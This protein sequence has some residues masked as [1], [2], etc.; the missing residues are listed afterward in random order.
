[1]KMCGTCQPQ[2]TGHVGTKTNSWPWGAQHPTGAEGQG[3]YLAPAPSRYHWPGTPWLWSRFCPFRSGWCCTAGK[4]K[5]LGL[6]GDGNGSSGGIYGLPSSGMYVCV[7]GWRDVEEDG[8]VHT[9]CFWREKRVITQ[10]FTPFTWWEQGGSSGQPNH[11]QPPTEPSSSMA[12]ALTVSRSGAIYKALCQRGCGTACL[13]KRVKKKNKKKSRRRRGVYFCE[14][15]QQQTI[16]TGGFLEP[17]W[18]AHSQGRKFLRSVPLSAPIP[19][20]WPGG[21]DR[22][23]GWC[24]M[25]LP[26]DRRNAADAQGGDRM[27]S[28]IWEGV[29]IGFL[30]GTRADASPERIVFLGFARI[31]VWRALREL[32]ARLEGTAV[33]VSL[34]SCRARTCQPQPGQDFH[35]WKSK[36]RHI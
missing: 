26:R 27:M 21:G 22:G 32:W 35:A 18:G 19:L 24:G 5:M 7:C 8:C 20:L 1:M 34:C 31:L 9:A 11:A 36:S 25:E 29:G 33:P 14:L 2:P 6:G 13:S 16:A 4:E 28:V 17:A 30:E 10:R 23:R 12:G 3:P 15:Q